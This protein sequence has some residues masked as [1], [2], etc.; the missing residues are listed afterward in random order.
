VFVVHPLPLETVERN[1]IALEYA[2]VVRRV[3][4]A[5]GAC[6]VDGW[7]EFRDR[8]AGD[9]LFDDFCHPSEA[10]HETLGRATATAIEREV[11]R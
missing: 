4:L 8:P 10:G 6:L 11:P 2:D 9:A 5:T 1:P 3:A 7:A